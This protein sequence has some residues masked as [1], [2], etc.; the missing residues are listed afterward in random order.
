MCRW[1]DNIKADIKKIGFEDVE[2][3]HVAQDRV[4]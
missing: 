3:I 1:E 4:C 2:W